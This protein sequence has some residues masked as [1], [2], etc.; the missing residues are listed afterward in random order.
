MVVLDGVSKR[1]RDAWAVRDVNLEIAE[2]E[3]F[4][5][6]GPSGCGKTTT[7][8][9]MNRLLD[10]S[11]G[12][13]S[14]MGQSVHDGEPAILRRRIGY[15]I[16]DVGLFAHYTVRRNVAVVPGLLG[17][18]RVDIERR[19][20][21]L[22]ELVGLGAELGSRFP[23][24]LS[25]GQR[26]RVGIARALAADPPLVLLDEPFGALDPI[27]REAL[28]DELSSLARR[29]K[30]TFVLVTHDVFEAVRL[31]SRIAVMN[32]G[33]VEQVATPHELVRRPAS[34]LV[35]K[36]LGRH[37]HQLKLMTL[38]ARDVVTSVVP[39]AGA[40]IVDLVPDASV[41]HALDRLES[42]GAE[43]VRV[44]E[45]PQARYATRRELLEAS[46]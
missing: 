46:A 23:A 10:P 24:E 28:Q 42:S 26:Q 20:D 36:M 15:V 5:L 18:Q 34:E 25:G 33:R 22:L 45:G 19:V 8:R 27:T 12:R 14:V 41:W 1:F 30:K 38:S 37:R 31:G 39:A 29:L 6:I 43:V 44:G 32:A 2:G 21:E 9:L 7:L 13:V 4:V 16:Q 35:E 17:W 3:T 11:E 40:A